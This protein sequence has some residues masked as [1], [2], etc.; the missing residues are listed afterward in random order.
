[1]AYKRILVVVDDRSVSRPAIFHAVEIARLHHA[2]LFFFFVLPGFSAPA[3]DFPVASTETEQE[4]ERIAR[5][6]ASK[7]LLEASAIA[8][9]KACTATAQWGPASPMPSASLKWR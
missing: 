9:R 4:Y 6:K 7:C 8:R 2:E 1:M 5:S 3:F